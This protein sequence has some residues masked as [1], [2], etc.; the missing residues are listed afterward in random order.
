MLGIYYF[1]F[2]GLKNYD[3][4]IYD[5]FDLS[6]NS[7]SKHD[8]LLLGS[9]RTYYG[10]NSF[11]LEKLT[12]KNVF[13][14]GLEGAK[15]NEMELAFNGYLNTHPNPEVVYLMVDPHS[16]SSESFIYNKIYFS[17]YL[18]NDSIY[19]AMKNNV[20][21]KA[22]LW[23][24]L[25]YSIISEFDDYTRIK[26]VRGLFSKGY[27]NGSIFDYKGFS[28]LQK[29]FKATSEESDFSKI[30]LKDRGNSLENIIIS[31]V[32]RNI[33]IQIIQGPFLE[34]YYNSNNIRLF[35]T[36]LN[37]KLYEKFPSI[38]FQNVPLNYSSVNYFKDETHL[39]DLGSTKY[40]Y[41]L[42]STFIKNK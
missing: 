1:I 22:M 9:S 15:I 34:E 23:K 20:G 6:F 16:F 2:S 38:S 39:N 40:T 28:L 26:S 7:H 19:N 8:I 31:C 29:K 17:N 14:L 42:F 27:S 10:I 13:N 11:L 35:Y 24:W 32:N 3:K 21:Y 41:D 30:D 33:D 25:P 4:A 36:M 12:K 37:E 5:K 18:N